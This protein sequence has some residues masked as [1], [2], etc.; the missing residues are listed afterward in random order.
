MD[1]NVYHRDAPLKVVCSDRRYGDVSVALIPFTL[2]EEF[3]CIHET[4]QLK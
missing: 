1:R 2:L 3:Q 4:D